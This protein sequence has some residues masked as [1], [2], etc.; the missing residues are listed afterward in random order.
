L[1]PPQYGVRIAIAIVE[2]WVVENLVT[3]RVH[4]MALVGDFI[5]AWDEIMADALDKWERIEWEDLVRERAS[6]FIIPLTFK[7]YDDEG[8]RKIFRGAEGGRD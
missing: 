1:A 3:G 2:G 8:W 7:H 4:N 6:P 5:Q